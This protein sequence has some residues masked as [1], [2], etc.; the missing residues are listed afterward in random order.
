MV[1]LNQLHSLDAV[2]SLRH[3]LHA[4]HLVEQVGQ[5]LAS[6]LFVVDDERG[7]SHAGLKQ[8]AA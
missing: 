7:E 2:G 3:D 1:L 4:A 5:L 6:Q 8:N